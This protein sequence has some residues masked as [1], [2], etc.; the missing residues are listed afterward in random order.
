MDQDHVRFGVVSEERRTPW[1][2]LTLLLEKEGESV[3]DDEERKEGETSTY[4]RRTGL[5]HRSENQ[6]KQI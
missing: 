1:P 5:V 3:C 4:T 2:T 6:A